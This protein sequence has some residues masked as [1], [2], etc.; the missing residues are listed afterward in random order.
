[1][2]QEELLKAINIH[3]HP[4]GQVHASSPPANISQKQI[5]L[6]THETHRQNNGWDGAQPKNKKFSHPHLLAVGLPGIPRQVKVRIPP[7]HHPHDARGHHHHRRRTMRHC[8]RP[9]SDE[10]RGCQGTADDGRGK[11]GW[12]LHIYLVNDVLLMRSKAQPR[13]LIGL[14]GMV[15]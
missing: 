12:D 8:R 13:V 9:H 2:K 5:R 3:H 4:S 7:H 1:M 14:S 15:G 10:G 11:D 6:G